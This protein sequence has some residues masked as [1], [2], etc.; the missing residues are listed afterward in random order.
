MLNISIKISVIVPIYNVEQYLPEALDSICNQSL[1]DIEIICIND[2]SPD[3]SLNILKQYRTID[4][5]IMIIDQENAGVASARNVGINLAKGEFVA[6]VDPDDYYPSEDILK[7]LYS[8]AKE[9]H[10]DICGGSFSW[11]FDGTIVTE[12]HDDLI[13]YTFLKDGIVDYSDYQFDYGFTR[14]IYKTQMLRENHIIFPS[15]IRFQDPPFFVHAMV[16]AQKFFALKMVSYRYRKGH[17]NIN[18]ESFQRVNDL[19]R[20]LTDNLRLSEEHHLSKLHALTVQRFNQSYYKPIINSIENGNRELVD[21][22]IQAN[23]T[24]NFS[25]LQEENYEATEVYILRPLKAFIELAMTL[26]GSMK[27]KH[28]GT[29]APLM[30][31]NQHIFARFFSKIKECGIKGT[32]KIIIQKIVHRNLR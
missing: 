26:F 21:L 19:V 6:F 22:L 30:Q 17:Q 28:K 7:N 24:L 10:V 16:C 29:L 9:N 14:F 11:D 23:N 3:N 18:W 25:L 8:A 5:R 15:Y 27:S 20:G 13:K 2:G 1:E 12:Y 4:N 31:K 32:F